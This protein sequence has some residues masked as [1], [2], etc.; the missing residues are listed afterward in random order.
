MNTMNRARSQA[1]WQETYDV[2]VVGAGHAGIEASLAAARLGASVLCLAISLDQVANLPCNPSIGGTAKGQLV[3]EIDALGG[4]MGQ[5][6]DQCTLQFRMLNLSR[7]AAVYS[8]RAQVDRRRYQALA[9]QYLEAEPRVTLRQEEVVDLEL[10]ENGH[11]A[12]VWTQLGSFYQSR[13]VILANGTY[14]SSRIV[15]GEQY[16]EAGPDCQ[17]PAK[18]LGQA[19]ASL[20]LRLLRYKTGTPPRLHAEG[21]DWQA[22]EEQVDDKPEGC[23]SFVQSKL[24]KTEQLPRRS[25]WIAWTN[26]E[27]HALIAA[28]RERSP[29]FSGLIEGVGPRYC[30]SIE[31]KVQRFADRERHQ[32]FLEPTSAEGGEIYMQGLSTSLPI[33]VQMQII[34]GIPGLENARVERFAYAIEYDALEASELDL[35]LAVRRIPGLFSAGQLNGSSGYEEA[36]AQGL[37][38]GINAVRYIRGQAPAVLG[39]DEA[40]IGVLIDDLVTKGSLEPYRMM[41]AR[42][43][44]RLLLRQDNADLRLTPKGRDWGLIDD[45]RW[46]LFNQKK[47]SLEA[48]LL[49]CRETLIQVDASLQKILADKG[50]QIQ[51]GRYRL[52]QLLTRPHVHYADLAVWDPTRPKDLAVDVQEEVDIQ[53]HYAGYIELDR[54]RLEHFQKQEARLL[55]DPMPYA[56]IPGLSHEAREKLQRYQPRS[57][58]QA[59]RIAGVSPADQ[60]LLLLWME[61]KEVGEG[62]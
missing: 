13:S 7:G 21:I 26:P 11:I 28:N 36:A 27:V 9:K 53:C 23:F 6:A 5:L 19:L 45:E 37:M 56:E 51:L 35:T 61:Q 44:W 16:W 3:R 38:A 59:G 4:V 41:T 49:R 40:Y 57:L 25:C 47:A 50:E 17:F 34:Q 24:K 60:Q 10:D 2:I 15:I 31:D 43:E 33:D 52:Q 22:L 30:P 12:G 29:L 39:R 1:L 58:G 48:E 54:Q 46:A 32:I 42:A 62:L 8:P 20:G 18:H 55:P 14:L